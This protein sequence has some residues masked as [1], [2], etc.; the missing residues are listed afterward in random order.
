MHTR[1]HALDDSLLVADLAGEGVVGPAVEGGLGGSVEGLAVG[2]QVQAVV[3]TTARD[4]HVGT[5][6]AA[7]GAEG[8][9]GD[10]SSVL[11]DEHVAFGVPDDGSYLL[12]AAGDLHDG[13]GGVDGVLVAHV[14]DA[15]AAFWERE[16]GDFSVDICE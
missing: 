6:D 7:V 3:E 14:G 11:L 13:P 2:S 5:V 15:A 9:D 10:A 4:K 8:V 12:Q 1:R 16:L